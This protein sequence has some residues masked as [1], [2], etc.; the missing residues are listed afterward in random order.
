M[1]EH[2]LDVIKDIRSRVNNADQAA[3]ISPHAIWR[4]L[5][6]LQKDRAELL[7]LLD[8]AVEKLADVN[9]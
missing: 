7:R 6:Q 9:G 2:H 4:T 1:N 8:V 5:T 3:N